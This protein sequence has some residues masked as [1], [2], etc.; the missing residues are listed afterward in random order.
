MLEQSFWLLSLISP[1]ILVVGIIVGLYK[2][3]FLQNKAVVL[4]LYLII[5]FCIDL[6][7]RLTVDN[8]NNLY[9]IPWLGMLELILFSVYFKMK[10]TGNIIFF[11]NLLGVLYILAE[12]IFFKYTSVSEYQPYAR[13]VSSS[14]IM[15]SSMKFTLDTIRLEFKIQRIETNLN[16]VIL[17]YF[18]IQ[19]ICLLP[20][21]YLVNHPSYLTIGIWFFNLFIH[22]LFYSYLLIYLWKSGSHMKQSSFG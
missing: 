12:L 18:F 17:I 2:I 19:L 13:T 4:W 8:H 11:L 9:L 7:S 5:C 14:L 15:I 1:V 16:T 21:N 10:N 3:K 22:L 20:L 6:I